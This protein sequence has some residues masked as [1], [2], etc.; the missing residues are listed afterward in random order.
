MVANRRM[1]HRDM[2]KLFIRADASS[3][4][5]TGHVMR[6]LALAQAWKER[7]TRSPVFVCADIPAATRKR[8]E[9]EGVLLSRIT[10]EAGSLQD[11][12]QTQDVIR[13]HVV[14]DA[15]EDVWIVTDGYA[16]GE[17]YQS[18]FRKSGC[19]VMVV[20]DYNHLNRYSCDIL[21]NQN[22]GS[23]HYNYNCTRETTVLRGP[24]FAM[25]RHEF[26][27]SLQY[28]VMAEP[29]ELVNTVKLL[30][31]MGGADQ[32]DVTGLVLRALRAWPGAPF[33]IRVV[34][35]A[36]YEHHEILSGLAADSP[37]Q[38][39]ILNTVDDMAALI[40]WADLAVTAG[41]S[42]CWELLAMGVPMAAVI[43]AENQ[44]SLVE[45]LAQAGVAMNLGWYH[46]LTE[47][48]IREAVG[49][50]AGA[51][52]RRKQMSI[53]GRQ[54]VDGLGCERILSVMMGE[55][56]F[57][58]EARASDMEWWHEL[59]NEAGTRAAS[60]TPDIIAVSDHARW[61]TDRLSEA[62]SMLCVAEDRGTRI[63]ILRFEINPINGYVISIAV[64]PEAR[65]RGYGKKM[66]KAG[67]ARLAE[68]FGVDKVMAFIKP[69]N[70]ASIRAFEGADYHFKGIG[71]VRGQPAAMYGWTPS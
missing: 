38:V 25:L 69:D 11:M 55:S 57:L 58:R 23:E 41:G 45:K 71:E 8:L 4:I 15:I 24:A 30:V 16:F 18:C 54:L 27:G 40:N 3:S 2:T 31:T 32:H 50:L 63:G 59:A 1:V 22:F 64:A 35:G 66:I 36:A 44:R 43:L 19:H 12:R 56:V 21:L 28:L 17:S 52:D 26:R 47:N 37:H 13:H 39:I 67:T 65:G 68:R 10:G 62:Q 29:H 42:T 61:Y 5:G 49:E 70:T 53:K 46:A 6:M 14:N 34:I 33:E 60:F 20:D 7:T 51:T 48:A 9:S